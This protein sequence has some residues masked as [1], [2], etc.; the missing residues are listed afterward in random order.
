MK[1]LQMNLTLLSR[2]L[3]GG[4]YGDRNR[5]PIVSSGVFWLECSVLALSRASTGREKSIR[6]V[7]VCARFGKDCGAGNMVKTTV[8]FAKMRVD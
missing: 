3:E 5:R 4:Y 1:S 6:L 2:T 8:N 7:A